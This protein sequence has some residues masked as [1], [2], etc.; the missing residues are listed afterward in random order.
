MWR[1]ADAASRFIMV[2]AAIGAVAFFALSDIQPAG[3]RALAAAI[4]AA[5]AAQLLAF[6]WAVV[7]DS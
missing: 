6:L 5:G 1:E 2:L 4:V 3:A 7:D